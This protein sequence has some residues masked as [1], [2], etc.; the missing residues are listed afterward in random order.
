MPEVSPSQVPKMRTEFWTGGG[1]QAQTIKFI[2][3]LLGTD[4][5]DSLSLFWI[6][7]YVSQSEIFSN[8]LKSP[9]LLSNLL[10]FF[11]GRDNRCTNLF[12]WSCGKCLN[13][14][15]Y[16]THCVTHKERYATYI[17]DVLLPRSLGPL[18]FQIPWF[19]VVIK[20]CQLTNK[21]YGILKR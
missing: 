20:L 11:I 7:C 4:Q 21:Y 16:C 3:S 12:T 15:E 9:Q 8:P 10:N 6:F 1:I 19:R 18:V 5:Q 14:Y 13:I 17:F 2:Q